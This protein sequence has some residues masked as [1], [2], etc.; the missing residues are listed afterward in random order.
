MAVVLISLQQSA[1]P[2]QRFPSKLQNASSA[3]ARRWINARSKSVTTLARTGRYTCAEQHRWTVY[4]V[5]EQNPFVETPLG[6]LWKQQPCYGP[7]RSRR[8]EESCSCSTSVST[9]GTATAG[10]HEVKPI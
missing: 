8:A 4:G 9:R 3:N 5:K 10:G 2:I 7:G 1:P 6:S